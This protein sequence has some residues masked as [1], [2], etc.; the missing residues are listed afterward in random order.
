[1]D[2]L[3]GPGFP[4]GHAATAVV[5]YGLIAYLLMPYLPS[6]GWRVFAFLVAGLLALLIGYSRIYM[7]NHFPTD[8]IAGYAVGL[9]W[10]GLATTT[11]ETLA[12]RMRR[13]RQ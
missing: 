12:W 8:V 7:G 4:S 6:R 10:F 13:G 3:P 11:V 9:A 5:L 1:L 2:P